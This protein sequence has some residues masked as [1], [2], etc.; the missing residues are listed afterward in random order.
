MLILYS[1]SSGARKLDPTESDQPSVWTVSGNEMVVSVLDPF[2][3]HFFRIVKF[4][5]NADSDP[6]RA[7]SVTIE[8]ICQIGIKPLN[9]MTESG[10]FSVPRLNLS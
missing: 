8:K 10:N 9:N 6:T 5:P 1:R 3:K 7:F 4:R 2:R